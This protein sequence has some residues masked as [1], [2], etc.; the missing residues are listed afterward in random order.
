MTGSVLLTS[1]VDVQRQPKVQP[2]LEEP[3]GA[4][5]VALSRVKEELLLGCACLH[6]HLPMEVMNWGL[7]LRVCSLCQCLPQLQ[8]N[9]SCGEQADRRLE[10][11]ASLT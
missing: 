5:T 7:F 9:V 4:R 2:G 1:T 8:C 10:G 11:S 3:L 6:S